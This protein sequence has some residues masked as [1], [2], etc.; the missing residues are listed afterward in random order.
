M[1]ILAASCSSG[2]EGA[3]TSG[4]AANPTTPPATTSP[5]ATEPKPEGVRLLP[6]LKGLDQPVDM[7]PIPG[8][9]RLAVVEKAGVVRVVSVEDG[10]LTD[11]VLLDIR[12]DVTT[13]SEQGL[14]AIAFPPDY[15]EGGDAY[16]DY[17]DANGD[18]HIA[19]LDT[20]NGSLTDL[21]VIDQP[22]ANHNG[23]ALAFGPDGKL[24]VGMGDGGSAGDPEGNAQ[25][26]RSMLGKILRFDVSEEQPKPEQFAYGLRNPWRID[27]DGDDLWIADVGQGAWEEVDRIDATAAPGANL[28]WD[29]YEGD[30]V[31]EPQDIDESRLVFPVAAYSHELGCSITGGYVYRGEN[32]P[33]LVGR[34]VYGDFCSG[35]IWSLATSGGEPALL[36]KVNV[37][38]LAS[39][40]V[41]ADGELYAISLDGTIERFAPAG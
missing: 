4:Q 14:L 15:E 16:V 29:A 30:E 27:F 12:G 13:G 11:E 6:F 1:L 10:R 3:P 19:R 33:A 38:S 26:R 23:G 8:T 35:R 20:S 36:G 28:G 9:A 32:V 24:Y 2:G 41:D 39:F 18:T 34:Y 25:N 40:G 5:S 17:T 37:P 22:Y 21:I 7:Q 31:Y